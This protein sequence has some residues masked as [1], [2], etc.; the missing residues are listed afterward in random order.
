MPSGSVE[1][2]AVEVQ[3]ILNDESV[4]LLTWLQPQPP[5]APT[6]YTVLVSSALM[7]VAG[8]AGIAQE[9]REARSEEPPSHGR[10]RGGADWRARQGGARR[11]RWPDGLPGPPW[12]PWGARL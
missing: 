5:Y 3:K 12:R 2:T 7:A 9:N 6:M 11:L 1:D 8:R 4:R 10:Y